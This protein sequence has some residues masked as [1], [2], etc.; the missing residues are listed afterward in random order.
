MPWLWIV[1]GT[2]EII[3]LFVRL[4]LLQRRRERGYQP[5]V[6]ANEPRPLKPRPPQDC[7]V[8]RHPHPKLLWGHAQ[9]P[10]LGPWSQQKSPRGK[11]QESCTAGHA[12]PNPA[13]DYWGNTDPTFPALVGTGV[14][15]D[16]HQL[17]CQACGKRFS[18]RWGTALYRLQATAR[19][20][21][22]VLL[23]VKLGRSRADVQRLFGHAA[24]VLPIF[25]VGNSQTSSQAHNK[26]D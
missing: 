11:H 12:G 26:L 8:C 21:S 1:Y 18:S 25:V 14:R 5:V 20:I 15:S 16:I 3:T 23:A 9:K 2:L 10:G 6:L 7:P 17:K 24:R 22:R 19:D 4:E 13:C